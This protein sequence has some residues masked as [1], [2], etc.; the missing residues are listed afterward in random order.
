MLGGPKYEPLRVP[1][2]NFPEELSRRLSRSLSES[3]FRMQWK[4]TQDRV[5]NR[6][7]KSMKVNLTCKTKLN[8]YDHHVRLSTCSQQCAMTQVAALPRHVHGCPGRCWKGSPLAL[9]GH[10]AWIGSYP[11]VHSVHSVRLDCDIMSMGVA[12][13]A[14]QV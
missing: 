7:R 6:P 11:C 9:S 8:V 2:L 1:F 4:F 13:Q 14:P 10:C 12:M 3:P 5:E